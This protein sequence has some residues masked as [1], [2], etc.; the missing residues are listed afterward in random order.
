ML[1]LSLIVM[2]AKLNDP[3]TT[4]IHHKYASSNCTEPPSQMMER[5]S[6]VVWLLLSLCSSKT[7]G[8]Q[9]GSSAAS[10][11]TLAVNLWATS[12][13][14]WFKSYHSHIIRHKP[15]FSSLFWFTRCA[16]TRVG[17]GCDAKSTLILKEVCRSQCIYNSM[18]WFCIDC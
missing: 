13:R 4:F 11:S 6:C 3:K 2:P 10:M 8:Q 15:A 12:C 14:M 5:N 17:C 18:T 7:I 16:F 9:L 1:N